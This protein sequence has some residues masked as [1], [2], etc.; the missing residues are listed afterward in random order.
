ME[1]P[2]ES[3]E[4]SQPSASTEATPTS[5]EDAVSTEVGYLSLQATGETRYIGSSSGIGLASIISHMVDKST[6][7]GLL[8]TDMREV[9]PPGPLNAAGYGV[10]SS[11]PPR[12]SAMPFIEAYFAHTHITF[13]LLHRTSFLRTVE[14][15]YGE[16]DYYG[17]HVYDAFV[18]DLVLSIGSSN[19][20]RF[21]DAFASSA[22]HYSRA[23]AKLP[24]VLGMPGVMPLR[25]IL[26]LS[27]HGIF[28]NLRD[29]S[30]S[31]WHLIG[32]GVRICYEMGLHLEPKR[33]A[34]FLNAQTRLVT[35]EEEMNRRCFWCLYNLDRQVLRIL[36]PTHVC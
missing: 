27:Q 30:A 24:V 12:H 32:I 16:P 6:G 20:N 36:H 31:I 3:H 9:N 13:P 34:D 28:S 23:Q 8:P 26:L 1:S 7:D 25:A 2:E 10:D 19:F 4:V 21:G 11:L 22:A 15:M 5:T 14:Q 17:T 33:S 18:F 35:F 29:T